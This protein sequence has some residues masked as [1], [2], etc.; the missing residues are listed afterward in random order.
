MSSIKSKFS[1]L[2]IFG[3]I[4]IPIITIGYPFAVF[5]LSP[6]GKA[7][8]TMEEYT[9]FGIFYII[10]I[11]FMFWIMNN[12][13]YI[14]LDNTKIGF[15]NFYSSKTRLIPLKYLDGYIISR[16]TGKHGEN[17]DVIYLIKNK[18]KVGWICD[19]FYDNFFEIQDNLNLKYLG[20][21]NPRVIRQTLDYFEMVIYSR[22]YLKGSYLDMEREVY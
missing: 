15:R 2:S 22:K 13:K 11:L 6:E 17:Y 4:S 18:K 3:L 12:F 14:Y 19:A 21:E 9:S 16:A 10:F 1:F 7:P 8:N 20:S 5:L